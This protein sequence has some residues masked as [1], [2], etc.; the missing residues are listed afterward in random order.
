MKKSGLKKIISIVSFLSFA[1]SLSSL[2][3]YAMNNGGAINAINNFANLKENGQDKQEFNTVDEWIAYYEGYL[4]NQERFNAYFKAKRNQLSRAWGAGASAYAMKSSPANVSVHD[5]S[6]WTKSKFEKVTKFNA[7]A[8]QK[9]LV[10]SNGT[11]FGY[12]DQKHHL[13]ADAEIQKNMKKNKEKENSAPLETKQKIQIKRIIDGEMK[14][15][16]KND[17]REYDKS[18]DKKQIEDKNNFEDFEINNGN[19]KVDSNPKDILEKSNGMNK[20][21]IESNGNSSKDLLIDKNVLQNKDKQVNKKEKTLDELNKELNEKVGINAGANASDINKF[22]EDKKIKEEIEVRE[23]AKPL[24]QRIEEKLDEVKDDAAKQHIN[25]NF[26]A[27][28]QRESNETKKSD[29]TKKTLGEQIGYQQKLGQAVIDNLALSKTG[30]NKFKVTHAVDE[31]GNKIQQTTAEVN[32]IGFNEGRPGNLNANIEDGTIGKKSK[33]NGT[34]FDKIKENPFFF[35]ALGL[36][37][38]YTT[39]HLLSYYMD[40][41]LEDMK[42]KTAD[43]NAKLEKIRALS[44]IQ[45][46]LKGIN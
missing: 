25:A 14:K 35:G 7:L 2:S 21:M 46:T 36:G 41:H 40:V 45:E 8:M 31:K 15:T 26:T 12:N 38:L 9:F 3:L 5:S 10:M 39:Y 42:A 44:N 18:L 13:K 20:V 23:K 29:L 11:V 4:G 22:F 19:T 37:T 33:L 43:K 16:S 27:N 30:E 32:A 28:L 34:I 6:K 24:A 1:N 17:N